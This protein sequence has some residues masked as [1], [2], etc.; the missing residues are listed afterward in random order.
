VSSRS[1]DLLEIGPSRE[2]DLLLACGRT[3]KSSDVAERI[4]A[5]AA[6]GLDSA[7]LLRLARPHGLMPLLH[8]HLN[9]PEIAAVSSDARDE[10]RRHFESNMRHNLRLVAELLRLLELLEAHGISAVPF[11]GPVLATSTYG[12]LALR[13]FVDLDIVVR[14][15]D[16]RAATRILASQGYQ[17]VDGLTAVQRDALIAWGWERP[18][19]N[20][21][22]RVLVDLHWRFAPRYF[23]V[24]LDPERLWS[25]RQHVSL[26]GVSTSAFAPEDLLLILALHGAKHSWSRI[27]WVCGIAEL[28]RATAQLDWPRMAEEAAR[29][30]SL[31][32]L[33]LGIL[34][35]H[36]L[37]DAPV[38]LEI[39]RRAHTDRRAAALA[40]AVR[41]RLIGGSPYEPGALE[42]VVFDC[43]VRE[44]LADKV[45]YL[46]RFASQ[47]NE[48]DLAWLRLPSW[49]S[50]A[51]YLLRPLRL[52][53]DHAIPKT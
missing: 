3:H 10:L 11:K 29:I 31:R 21:K 35:A 32:I 41:C 34:L 5:L 33:W 43:A 53:I 24:D 12:N 7:T 19:W 51:Y 49:L 44:R 2:A 6:Q 46:I 26:G 37:L 38:P 45:R 30:G 18:L 9:D 1:P 52:I 13:E 27:E 22:L 16:V 48:R 28:I 14:R 4:R 42:R 23:S 36:E 17:T 8:W 25:R 15:R 20:S 47:P 39:V 50:F 40:G